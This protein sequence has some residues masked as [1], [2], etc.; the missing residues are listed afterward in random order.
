MKNA[1]II[2]FLAFALSSCGDTPKSADKQETLSNQNAV[3]LPKDSMTLLYQQYLRELESPMPTFQEKKAGKLFPVDEAPLDTGFFV[4]RQRLLDAIERRDVFYL[5]EITNKDIK[6]SFGAEQGSADM[7]KMW[8]LDGAKTD[9]LE[10]WSI[11]QS[12]LTQ[13][14][15]FQDNRNAFVAPY[16]FATWPEGYDPYDFGVLIGSGVRLRAAPSQQAPINHT[17]SYDIVTVLSEEN[18]ET[19][20]GESYPWVR[21]ALEKEGEGYVYGKYIGYPI[22]Y[23]VG[24]QRI[25]GNHW[26]MNFFVAGD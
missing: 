2:L 11:L 22:G 6:I 26:E 4:F 19:I 21:V 10:I 12:A 17:V 13:G 14:G 23:R 16:Y 7:V 24:F 9:T 20:E 5:M 18:T 8:G 3:A 25:A 15:V 1:S